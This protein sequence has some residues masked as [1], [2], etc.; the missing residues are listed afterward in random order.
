MFITH[1]SV[2]YI[3][4]FKLSGFIP[5]WHNRCTTMRVSKTKKY[6][7]KQSLS[8][9][10]SIFCPLKTPTSPFLLYSAK[11][12]SKTSILQAEQEPL[13]SS[14]RQPCRCICILR[15]AQFK[16]NS[17]RIS[18]LFLFFSQLCEQNREGHIKGV[19]FSFFPLFH[20][21]RTE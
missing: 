4:M 17:M 6:P 9:S 13:R 14:H 12:S 19:S 20:D 3:V 1:H 18:A 21:N 2:T 16:C 10:L 11:T 5:L 15:A 8:G 7:V